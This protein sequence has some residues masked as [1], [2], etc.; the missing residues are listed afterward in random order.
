MVVYN[1]LGVFPFFVK[2]LTDCIL[3]VFFEFRLNL[4]RHYL[5]RG[6]TTNLRGKQEISD[7]SYFDGFHC[8][9]E[10]IVLV[11]SLFLEFII[12]VQL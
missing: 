5:V 4:I 7:G 6:V 2:I 8:N 1:T 9:K 3:P 12:T 11:I 10:Q